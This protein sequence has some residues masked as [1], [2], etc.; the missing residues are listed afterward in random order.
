[1]TGEVS[2]PRVVVVTGTDT[3]V[4]KTVVTAALAARARARGE[5]V[6]VVKPVQTG[7]GGAD[8]DPGD[9]RE[10]ERLTGVEVVEHVALD[11]PLAPD[12]AAARQGVELPTVA[13]HAA[14]IV[15]VAGGHDLVLVEGAGGS[16]VRLD[17]C[18]GTLI[19]LAGGLRRVDEVALEVVVVTR[20]GLGTLNHTE[21]TVRAWRAAGIEPSGLVIGAWP[22]NPGLA[23]QCNRDDLPRHTSC[24]V[25][26]VVPAGAGRWGRV[27]FTSAARG[28]FA[29]DSSWGW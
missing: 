11:D 17:G 15:A 2:R 18:G 21:L 19:D 22:R 29:D 5:R 7:I 1:M 25:V 24:P 28:W 16:L 8:P 10:V 6:L 4:G 3:G 14:R 20:P 12:T 23:E 27:T 26:G 13:E 9:V